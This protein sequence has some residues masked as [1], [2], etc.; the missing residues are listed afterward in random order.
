MNDVRPDPE[1]ISDT[2]PFQQMAVADVPGFSAATV[3]VP[4]P[5]IREALDLLD[6][7]LQ[8][9]PDSGRHGNVIAVVGEYGTGKSHLVGDLLYHAETHS[10]PD[11]TRAVY[12]EAEQK[13]F[14][15]LY[16]RFVEHLEC[17]DVRDRV[18]EFYADVLADALAGSDFTANVARAVRNGDLDPV[19]AV[20]RLGLMESKHL[21]ELQRLLGRVTRNT[22]FGTALTLLLRPGFTAAAWEWLTGHTPDQV[23]VDRGLTSA[24]ATEEAALEAMG[25]FAVLYSHRDRRFIVAIDELNKVVSA[26]RKPTENA[27]DAFKKMLDVFA[28]ARALLVLSGLPDSFE[29]L[30]K[31]VGQRV[32][33]VIS[34]APL[35][36]DDT[37]ELIRQSQARIGRGERLHPFDE[38]SV[39]YLVKV[40]EGNARRIVRLCHKLYRLAR[41]EA[42]EPE[43]GRVT[44]A[45]IRQAARDRSTFGTI[46]NVRTEIRRVVN[47]LGLEYVRDQLLNRDTDSRA[48][49][50]LPVGTDNAGC[51][52]LLTE[53]VLVEAEAEA[54]VNRAT[55]IQA[56]VE[57]TELILVVIGLVHEDLLSRLG[58]AFSSEPIIYDPWT[59]VDTLAAELAE[60]VRV[61]ELASGGDPLIA[62][63][64]RVS[65]VSRQQANTQ[66]LLEQVTVALAGMR[67]TTEREFA[68][69]QRELAELATRVRS[70]EPGTEQAPPLRLP[71][72]VAGLFVSAQESL[73]TVDQVDAALRTMFASTEHDLNRAIDARVNIRGPLRSKETFPALGVAS[74]LHRLLDA[75]R[76][77]INDWY[78]T[79]VPSPT[80]QVQ[81]GD[82]ERLS[83]LCRAYD[84]IYEYVPLF[85]LEGLDEFTPRAVEGEMSA[86]L[87]SLRLE[88]LK[89]TF[90]ELSNRV[91][92]AVLASVVGER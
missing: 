40:T 90:N 58:A 27:I 61:L 79:Y 53:S 60:R 70:G 57:R 74:L 80:G 66:R 24:I 34:V 47:G 81:P 67:G 15:N 22:A 46:D 9:P 6:G 10:D 30:G 41:D 83:A 3:S 17:D 77:G 75:F 23:L 16:K 59:F 85:R 89:T 19:D 26:S 91:Q 76:H 56:A 86:P 42:R 4:T 51:A 32:G 82:R 68:V 39:R 84:T 63:R 7:F 29:V 71:P 2:N 65:R 44:D 73:D 78:R 36:V 87:S 31:D 25:V 49:Y 33:R 38:Q 52:V 20:E 54:L 35:T 50:W 55:Y 21:G 48:D 72:N 13:T 5:A 8:A 69:L 43:Q 92:S 14:V 1:L 45:M 64:D 62:M 88:H 12:L 28:G 18:R 11:R 37:L